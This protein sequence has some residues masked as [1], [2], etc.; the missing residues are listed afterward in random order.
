M[1][2][3]REPRQ[4]NENYYPIAMEAAGVGIW[5]WDLLKNRLSWSKECKV[6]LGL[7]PD[8]QEDFGYY[9][10]LI[11]PDDRDRVLSLFAENYHSKTPH[12]VSYR[13]IHPDGSLHWVADRGRFLYDDQGKA[14]HITGVTWDITPQ[15]QAEE[16]RLQTDIHM[17]E[18][19]ASIGEAFL[20]LDQEWRFTYVNSRAA[21]MEGYL[22]ES[23][24]LG[25]N[26]W[27][28][29]PYL[30]GTPIEHYFRQVMETRKPAAFEVF[31]P[32]D[33]H[34]YDIRVYPADQGGITSFHADI[35]E[36]KALEQERDQWFAKEREARKEAEAAH[37][38]SDELVKQLE[39]KQAF[40]QAIMQQAP[41]GMIIADAPQ[42]RVISYN[43]EA[44]A[45]LGYPCRK[46]ENYA[47]Y[48]QQGALHGDGTPYSAE[49][50][51]LA[52]AI[53]AGEVIKQENMLCQ[54][55]DGRVIHLATNAAPI[56]DTRGQIQ[57]GIV[58]FQD[59][60][61]RY[62]LEQRKDEFVCLASHELRTP[63]TSLKGNLQMAERC[64]QRFLKGEEDLLSEK[65]KKLLEQLASWNERALRQAN[66][67]SRLI[68]DLLD[69]DSIQAEGLRLSLQASNL[70]QI[71]RNA[72]DDMQPVAQPRQIFFDAA[73]LSEVSVMVDGMRIGQVITNY[74]KNAL[75][76]A[77]EQEPVTVG[78]SLENGEVQVWVRDAGPGLP[79]EEQ[80]LIWERFRQAPSIAGYRGPGSGGLG[81]GLYICRELIRLHGGHTGV[82]SAPG[83]GSLFWFTL[84]INQSENNKYFPSCQKLKSAS[85]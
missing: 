14:V 16:A 6:V 47:A 41:S 82:E 65:E 36:R 7:P 64:L 13:I 18:I 73:D 85:T 33:R 56:Y 3:Q 32:R 58:I 27:E 35:T 21:Q 55:C 74:V 50:Y 51:P 49:E 46:D 63:L 77:I 12:N 48:A 68:N 20:H 25:K 67:E 53:H 37:C 9:L 15:K 83:Q 39:Q 31:H 42:G 43:E 80:R 2:N 81:L 69:A 54:R 70:V 57:A 38:R 29:S 45:I 84:P 5:N 23:E 28:V 72:V 78:I 61:E 17:R 59:I 10:S 22:H 8:A 60:S 66:V 26:F 44:I 19:L 62:E 75:K 4:F 30:I 24:L 40:L 11:H 34:W 79:L 71:V 1:I 76:Y 52:R